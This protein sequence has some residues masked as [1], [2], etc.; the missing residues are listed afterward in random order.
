MLFLFLSGGNCI[1]TLKEQWQIKHFLPRGQGE[2]HKSEKSLKALAHEQGGRGGGGLFP[3]SLLPQSTT[4]NTQRKQWN[5]IFFKCQQGHY[6]VP[7]IWQISYNCSLI[8]AGTSKC[9]QRLPF[10]VLDYNHSEKY[11]KRIIHALWLILT[12]YSV[13]KWKTSVGDFGRE[14]LYFIHRFQN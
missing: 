5:S 9:S 13:R 1:T 4:K 12:H 3:Y 2:G 8:P 6:P 11:Y 7:G 14:L 10:Y